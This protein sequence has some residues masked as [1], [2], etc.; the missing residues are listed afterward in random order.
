MLFYIVFS[1]WCKPLRVVSG[2]NQR[3]YTFMKLINF[4][5]TI[6]ALS[7]SSQ[8]T[9]SR[10][11]FH[12]LAVNLFCL[13]GGF[14]APPVIFLLLFPYF[15]LGRG[16]PTK[17]LH[18]TGNGCWGRS[19]SACF[20][21]DSGGGEIPICFQSQFLGY[22]STTSKHIWMSSEG[23]YLI[24]ILCVPSTTFCKLRSFFC[25]CTQS[26]VWLFSPGFIISITTGLC[27]RPPISSYL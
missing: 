18:W 26:C 8:L 19:R 25:C 12:Q 1:F 16:H 22:L 23:L 15:G 14:L 17:G 10:H 9:P 13:L 6:C 2:A 7:P 3:V 5:S 20:S 27:K 11:T 21:I 24:R 4:W